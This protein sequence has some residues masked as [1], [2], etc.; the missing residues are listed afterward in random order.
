MREH[1]PKKVKEM[2]FR[3]KVKSFMEST[4]MNPQV[5]ASLVAKA[6]FSSQQTSILSDQPP[7]PSLVAGPHSH[8][9]R[10]YRDYEHQPCKVLFRS[11]KPTY[12]DQVRS[13][14][15]YQ[16]IKQEIYNAVGILQKSDQ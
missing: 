14:R 5:L 2:Q 3:R 13:R 7:R 16:L 9:Q 8:Y 10:D 15:K 6:N 11:N 12:W 1:D 4:D